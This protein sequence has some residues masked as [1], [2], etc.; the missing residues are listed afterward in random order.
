MST[1]HKDILDDVYEMRE[2]FPAALRQGD[3]KDHETKK[4]EQ[5]IRSCTWCFDVDCY[6]RKLCIDADRLH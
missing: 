1:V 3:H 6:S 4:I 5:K 2:Y